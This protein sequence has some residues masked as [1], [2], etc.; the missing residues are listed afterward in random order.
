VY[1]SGP[2]AT[3]FVTW[4]PAFRQ[5]AW[6][7]YLRLPMRLAMSLTTRSQTFKAL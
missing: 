6:P 5:R 4:R 1:P 2:A 3:S 7:S